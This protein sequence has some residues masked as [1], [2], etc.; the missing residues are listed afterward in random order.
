MNIFGTTSGQKRNALISPLLRCFSYAQ[1]KSLINIIRSLFMTDVGHKQGSSFLVE[2]VLSDNCFGP[3]LFGS[4]P[5]KRRIAMF[6]GDLITHQDTNQFIRL[7]YSLSA[8]PLQSVP[9]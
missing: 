6:R 5:R 1:K 9:P 3:F 4:F 8:A 7:Y 2:I